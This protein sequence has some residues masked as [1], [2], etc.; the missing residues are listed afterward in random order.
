MPKRLGLFLSVALACT[1]L[2]GCGDSASFATGSSASTSFL[3]MDASAPSLLVMPDMGV[4]PIL[5]AIQGAQKSIQLTMYMFTDYD[6]T[7]QLVQ[8]LI[9]RAQAGVDVRVLIDPHPY[10]GPSHSDPSAAA[11]Q[12]LEQGGVKVE[13][14]SPDFRY[15]HEKAMVID[16]KTAYIMTCNFTNAAF[17]SNREYAVVDHDPTD[18]AEVSNIFRADWNRQDYT[19]SDPNL[20]VSP[21]NSHQQLLDLIDSARHSIVV[22]CEVIGDQRIADALGARAQD[23]VDIKVMLSRLGSKTDDRESQQL[24]DEGITQVEF[25]RHIKMH[26][27]A[28]VVD[29]QRAYIGSENLS[30]N[31]LDHNRELGLITQDRSLVSHLMSVQNEDWNN[32]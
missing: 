31:S 3:A 19:P 16:G 5:S 1:A 17:S 6:T 22:Q 11:V 25:N 21:T 20:V 24:A 28:I 26:A 4:S 10:V 15:T 13:D 23:G 12:A 9:A 32:D 8:A 2:V 18:V 29:G 27:K 30:T 7:G 14:S